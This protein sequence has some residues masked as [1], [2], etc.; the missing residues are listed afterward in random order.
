MKIKFKN[1]L[2]SRRII[3][4]PNGYK[5]VYDSLSHSYGGQTFK[6]ED[7]P[8]LN[9]MPSPKY[10]LIQPLP[11]RF[12]YKEIYVKDF[13]IDIWEFTEKFQMEICDAK[14]ATQENKNNFY[15]SFAPFLEIV[16]KYGLI[17]L[18]EFI[19]IG[20]PQSGIGLLP[21]TEE[22]LELQQYHHISSHNEFAS[23]YIDLFDYTSDLLLGHEEAEIPYGLNLELGLNTALDSNKNL[24]LT[25]RSIL[26][27]LLFYIL[28]KGVPTFDRCSQ[29]E[30]KFIKVKKSQEYCSEKCRI[31][32]Y[33]DREL[34]KYL[35]N[36]SSLDDDPSVSD[37]SATWN[38]Y[39]KGNIRI[40]CKCGA[41]NTVSRADF[42][43]EG[44]NYQCFHCID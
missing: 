14:D 20:F 10:L 23:S 15:L 11:G 32:S 40:Y 24:I 30:K 3:H 37:Y 36:F 25:P 35:K 18:K 31:E 16:N 22:Q 8:L 42:Q 4:H 26:G 38:D 19:G 43:Q 33:R 5:L 39:L 44:W 17:T 41:S 7:N 28:S 12:E 34:D 13:L 29:C 2:K 21:T 27:D 1:N 6:P 9:N